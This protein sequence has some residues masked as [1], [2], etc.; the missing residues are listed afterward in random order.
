MQYNH[1]KGIDLVKKTNPR[2]RIVAISNYDHEKKQTIIR[3]KTAL[4]DDVYFLHDPAN[5]FEDKIV[6]PE[7]YINDPLCRI[8]EVFNEV[9]LR[10]EIHIYK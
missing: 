2:G 1:I 10:K 7:K 4:Y 6:N 3:T 9:M 8:Y 5:D